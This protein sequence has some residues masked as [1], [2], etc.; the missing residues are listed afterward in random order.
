[1]EV[2]KLDSIVHLQ[3]EDPRCPWM[4]REGGSIIHVFSDTPESSIQ[5]TWATLMR[6]KD[7]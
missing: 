7:L 6:N 3:G 2:E 1:M 4:R 5:N